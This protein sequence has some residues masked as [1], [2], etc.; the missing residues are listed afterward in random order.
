MA[1]EFGW[2][3]R[4]RLPEVDRRRSAQVHAAHAPPVGGH[5]GEVVEPEALL[6]EFLRRA[7]AGQD[8]VRAPLVADGRG[9]P[10]ADRAAAERPPDVGGIDGHVVAEA[11][12]ELLDGVAGIPGSGA[13]GVG[14]PEEVGPAHVADQQCPAGEQQDRVLAAGVVVDQQA[15]VLGGVA[16]GVDHFESDVAQLDDLAVGDAAVVVTEV[17]TGEAQHLD[18]L[19]EAQLRQA[20]QVVVVPVGVDGVGDAQPM[21]PGG[22]EVDLHIPAGIEQERPTRLLVTHEIGRM[23]QTLQIELFEDHHGSPFYLVAS[24]DA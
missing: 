5:G 16:G 17:G 20:A 24:P 18:V 11:P 19:A 6:D 22:F 21:H 8:R 4:G 23:P 10:A 2:N 15:H 13:G 3:E 12:Q 9:Q 14:V 1:A 7:D